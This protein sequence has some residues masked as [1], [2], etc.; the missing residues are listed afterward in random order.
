MYF[1][2]FYL[3]CLAHASYMLASEGEAVVVDPQRDVEIYLKAAEANQVSIRHIFETHLHADF[4]SGHR[5]LA[6]RTGA[7][8]YIGAQA[9]ATFPHVAVRDGFQLRVG[10]MHIAALET[11]GHTPESVCLVITDEERSAASSSVEP[12]AVLTGDTLFIGDVG[13]P[14]LS[15][16][17]SPV[18]LAGMLYD[19]L[20]NKLF[21]LADSVL[22]Y[23]AHGAGSL[24]GR[25]MR[26]EKVSTIGTERL[27]NYALQIKGRE[28]FIEQ[29]TSNL[30][31]RP[32]YF[33]QDAEIN[34]TG[35]TTLAELP[36]LS[37]IEPAELKALLEEGGLALDVRPGEAFAV[38]HVPGSVNIALFGQFASWA[39]ALLGLDSRPVLIA[40]SEEAV[41]EARMRLARIGLENAR[42]YLKGGVEAWKRAGLPLE[43]LRQI[44][45]ED[46]S[47]RLRGE[48]IQVLDV[49]REREWED[50]HIEGA[51]WW[52]LDNFKV[53]PPEIDR[54]I[55]IAVHCKGGYR[56]LIACSLLQ[57]AGF[58][59]VVN[60]VGGFD[61]WQGA[62]LAVAA[63]KVVE[64]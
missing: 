28:E 13:R 59:K 27:T 34:R 20:H 64:A 7:K 23:P 25:N 43:A 2:Q 10:K 51:S 60:V 56:S 42:G 57:R 21:K 37:R 54:N 12:W 1:E 24:C 44:S 35:A 18:Q 45:V 26:A 55:P 41:A 63:E 8:I 29:L 9:G 58:Q 14:D 36:A 53:S 3:G 19:S 15:G 50:G 6:A 46:L 40:E 11:P 22:V 62:G 31:A 4:V 32:E 33:L 39:G 38:G 52:P 49:R 16:R 5:E 61:A 48:E 17:Y 30:P 47:Q